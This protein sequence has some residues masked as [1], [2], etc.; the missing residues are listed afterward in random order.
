LGFGNIKLINVRI[1]SLNKEDVCLQSRWH[2]SDSH[3]DGQPIPLDAM[4]ALLGLDVLQ[5]TLV[6]VN[7]GGDQ[8]SAG[9][10]TLDTNQH[11]AMLNLDVNRL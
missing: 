7:E 2:N 11:R 10:A 4:K 6:A 3:T 1:Y 5:L 9:S 8:T